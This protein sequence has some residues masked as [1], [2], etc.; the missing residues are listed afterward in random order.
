MLHYADLPV[1]TGSLGSGSHSPVS[2]Q[3]VEFGPISAS[4]GGQL[5]LKVVPS[6]GKT[7]SSKATTLGTESLPVDNSPNPQLAGKKHHFMIIL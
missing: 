5:K 2:V 7:V 3:V 4:P 6:T 1:H